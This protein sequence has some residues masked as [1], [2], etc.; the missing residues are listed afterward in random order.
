MTK[1]A[2]LTRVYKTKGTAGLNSQKLTVAIAAVASVRP[3]NRLGYP[4]HR[5]T[6]T[7]VDGT[8]YDLAN[9]YSEVQAAIGAR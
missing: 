7:L 6:I 4:D 2:K 9:T 1:F 5:S 3:S 8:T